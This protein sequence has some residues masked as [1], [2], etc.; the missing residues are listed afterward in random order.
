MNRAS[1]WISDVFGS[2]QTD[3]RTTAI[4][5]ASSGVGL[6][7]GGLAAQDVSEHARSRVGLAQLPDHRALR[8]QRASEPSN[9]VF[10]LFTL[11]PRFPEL[12]RDL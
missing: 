5:S 12:P 9:L 6:V 2:L 8:E 4:V 1:A 10:Q 3:A 7:A 11:R